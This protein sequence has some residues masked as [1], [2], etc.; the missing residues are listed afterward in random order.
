[1]RAG[2]PPGPDLVPVELLRI[3]GLHAARV[4]ACVAVS[5]ASYGITIAWRN[6]R[7][8]PAPKDQKV[9]LSLKN[10]RGALCSNAAGKAC[11]RLL[12]RHAAPALLAFAGP[13]QSGGITGG[14]TEFLA[15]A[16]RSF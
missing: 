6:G 10:S 2:S 5:A 7:M 14:G 4:L 15:M 16:L 8:V 1:M 3:G 9:G 13:L 11:A 12:R